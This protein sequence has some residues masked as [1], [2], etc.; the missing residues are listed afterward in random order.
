MPKRGI[1]DLEKM[2][3]EING[4]VEGWY[5]YLF[6]AIKDGVMVTGAVF[7]LV[8]R[9]NRINKPNWRKRDMNTKSTVFVP[10]SYVLKGAVCCSSRGIE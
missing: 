3:Q 6:E 7:P 1:G 10:D 9:G 2:S 8:T 5:P 4:N